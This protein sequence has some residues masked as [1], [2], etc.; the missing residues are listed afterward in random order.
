MSAEE[1]EMI[2][3]QQLFQLHIKNPY[4]EDYYY[5][6]YNAKKNPGKSRVLPPNMNFMSPAEPLPSSPRQTQPTSA[7]ATT[8]PAI[9]QTRMLG[10]IPTQSVRAPRVLIQLENVAENDAE[11]PAETEIKDHNPTLS[12]LYTIPSV[13][14]LSAIEKGLNIL[15]EIEDINLAIE[16]DASIAYSD[17]LRKRFL[18]YS[19]DLLDILKFNQ[20]S[21]EPHFLF[22]VLHFAKG[23]R[24]VSRA[25]QILSEAHVCIIVDQCMLNWAKIVGIVPS[26][27]DRLQ[28]VKELTAAIKR[29]KSLLLI[30]QRLKVLVLHINNTIQTLSL[31]DGL[32]FIVEMFNRCAVLTLQE[33]QQSPLT[34]DSHM[35]STQF[36]DQFYNFLPQLAR[37]HCINGTDSLFD[38]LIRIL[39]SLL[40]HVRRTRIIMELG[41]M[42]MQL[43][44]HVHSQQ[45]PPMIAPPQQPLTEAQIINAQ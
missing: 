36:F 18:K 44:Q 13:V 3:R 20:Q 40:D 38:E 27:P 34:S 19:H 9:V 7:D 30:Q 11:T 28:L 10:R 43:R 25:L 35:V 26:I 39:A 23:V 29:T 41:P 15:L 4:I 33:P 31:S 21:E 22:Q 24:L 2:I 32:G 1:V 6:T 42:V 17:E 45:P 16:H 37:V 14:T 8:S 12:T 5:F